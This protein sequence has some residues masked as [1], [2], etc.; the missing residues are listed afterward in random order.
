MKNTIFILFVLSLLTFTSSCTKWL[1]VQPEDR[2]SEE[3]VFSSREGYEEAING[4]YLN[5]SS[6]SLYGDNLTLTVPDIFAQ[7]FK[8]NGSPV[9][10]WSKIGSYDYTDKDVVKRFDAIWT[11]AYVAIANI[12]KLLE[13]IDKTGEQ[14]LGTDRMKTMKGELLGL[15]GFLHFDLFRF[16]GPIYDSKDSTLNSIPYY[17]QVGEEIQPLLPANNLLDSVL[18]D[19]NKA[20]PLLENDPVKALGY[21][22][23]NNQRFNYFS[24]LATKAR[25]LL[26][27]KDFAG[28]NEAAKKIVAVS[29]LL[30]PWI[31]GSKITAD[32][33]NPDRIFHT[34]LLFSVY[35]NDLYN[36]YDKYFHFELAYNV[37]AGGSD[38]FLEKIFETKTADYRYQTT[39]KPSPTVV[40]YR[41]FYKYADIAEKRPGLQMQRNVIPVIRLSE[42]YYI[43]AETEPDPTKALA[44]LNKVLNARGLASLTAGPNV[45]L[46]TEI[47]KEYRKEFFGEG[48]LWYYYKRRKITSILSS[49]PNNNNG[50]IPSSAW[51]VP[52]PDEELANR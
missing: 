4:I 38:L 50:T 32:L 16:Y 41:T 52:I 33:Q 11:E 28:A 3:Q 5:L 44:Y 13:N 42:M 15:R 7:L 47:L 30:F 35:S 22:L 51:V 1:N 39:W 29:D 9:N 18:S 10:K 14:V 36:N 37:L 27:R 45:D 34:E 24:V 12:N 31:V 23:Q 8:T 2:F 48:Q 6:N 43:L 19:I 25:I 21:R 40:P 49:F 46:K 20:L 26:L 17:S